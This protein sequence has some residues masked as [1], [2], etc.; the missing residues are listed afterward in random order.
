MT[1]NNNDLALEILNEL[2]TQKVRSS[3]FGFNG[4][5]TPEELNHITKI[6]LKGVTSLD[7]LEKLPNLKELNIFS[8]DSSNIINPDEADINHILDFSPLE[9]LK[10]LKTLRIYN[11]CFLES[12]DLSNMTSLH[13]VQLVNNTHL[14]TLRGLD[15]LMNL[16]EVVLL[17]N[18]LATIENIK[19]Y[20][21]HTKDT[22]VNV[23][24][25]TMFPN[26]F[27]ENFKDRRY[28]EEKLAM[29][30]SNLMFAEKVSFG[31]GEFI[32]TYDKVK[33]M[34]QRVKQI[35]RNLHI[36]FPPTFEDLKRIHTY[37]AFSIKYDYAGLE[38]RD[39]NYQSTLIKDGKEKDYFMNRLKLMNT[40]FGAIVNHKAV[41]EGYVNM[42][43]FMLNTLGIVA[44][45]VRVG[46]KSSNLD[47]AIIKFQYN[48]EWYYADPEKERE[49]KSID[50]FALSF[51]ELSRKYVL[52][53]KEYI[54]NNQKQEMELV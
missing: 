41:C 52:P 32:L 53:L 46:L 19:D 9:Q 54:D 26:L 28:L 11:D 23:F 24:D 49:T 43:I 29:E 45:Q 36:S 27:G 25:L 48:G 16:Q 51:D 34:Y 39:Q 2:I 14:Q 12:L 4:T 18:G 31:D 44:K 6:T 17:N 10:N 50:L 3:F 42:M 40:S 38:Y 5:F 30:M 1:I 47:H 13:R 15:K 21:E 35:I 8:D 20:I 7:D 37:I 22:A 33:N